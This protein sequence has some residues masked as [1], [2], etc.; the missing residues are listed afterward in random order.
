MR[1]FFLLFA[2]AYSAALG[3][4]DI[5]HRPPV[6]NADVTQVRIFPF[7]IGVSGRYLN[8]T[9]TLSAFPGIPTCCDLLSP[10]QGW[11]GSIMGEYTHWIGSKVSLEGALGLTSSSSSLASSSFV[12][13]ALDG[14]DDNAKV[15]RAESETRVTLSSYSLEGRIQGSWL[16]SNHMSSRPHLFGGFSAN[17]FLSGNLEQREQLLSPTSAVFEDTRTTTRLVY[18]ESAI[19]RLNPWLAFSAGI[20]ITP[21]QAERY[22]VRTRLSAELPLTRIVSESG[23]GLSYGLIRLDVSVM[24]KSAPVIITPPPTRVRHRM[25]AAD[26]K[27]LAR[28]AAGSVADTAVINVTQ[29]LGTRVYALLPFVFFSRGSAAIDARYNQIAGGNAL[30][31]RPS[32]SVV[33]ADTSSVSDTKATLELYYNLLNVVGRR[34]RTDYPDAT[35]S[36]KGYCD[37]QGVERN[38]T[39]LSYQR[40]VA[41]RNYLRDVWH[42]DTSRLV[43]MSG[44]L[45]PT[46]ASTTMSDERDRADG[47]EEN[48][49]VEMESTVAEVLDPVIISDTLLTFERPTVLAVPRI[50]SDSTDHDWMLS[51]AC[52]PIT[53]PVELRG[54]AS[55]L[56]QYTIDSSACPIVGGA[57]QLA[58]TS[59]LHVSAHDGRHVDATATLPVA[60]RTRTVYMRRTDGDTIQYRYRLTQFEYNNQRMLS[61]QTSIIKRY[62][63]PL[64][65]AHAKVLIYGFTDR[66]GPAELNLKLA[67]QR[68]GETVSAFSPSQSI[69]TFVVGEGISIQDVP[70]PNSTPEGRLYNRTVEVRVLVPVPTG[71]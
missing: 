4:L 5:N 17:Y 50:T 61:A 62:I 68:V 45:S 31:Y 65:P 22:D 53:Q 38:N 11:A 34:M 37:N 36:I 24:F 40:A 9:S 71:R 29:A 3:Q 1:L 32:T 47:H 10:T 2:A 28:D 23:K 8:P 46:A 66:K 48:R 43:V 44:V 52:S 56:P 69:E 12:G 41:V 6:T 18:S 63:S 39:T 58:I 19:S 49:R 25:L 64:L 59:T 42:I 21:L 51:T 35:L 27:L 67:Q 13:Y 70:F 7:S 30:T 16:L 54:S 55:P 57:E 33:L 20:G 60:A 14:T 26:L 15:V